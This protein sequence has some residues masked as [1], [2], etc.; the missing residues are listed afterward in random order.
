VPPDR[1]WNFA[2]IVEGIAGRYPDREAIRD[3]ARS[4][5]WRDF[6]R[7]TGALAAWLQERVSPRQ[8]TIAVY[9]RNCAEY[10]EAY[11]GVMKAGHV[12]MNV[13]F[14]Y[15][16]DEL[17]H[18]LD[19]ADVRL[20]VVHAEFLETASRVADRL[21]GITGWVVVGQ[22]AETGGPLPP[23]VTRYEDAVTGRAAG[24]DPGRCGS[25]V[26][27]MYT[28]GTTGL[29]K[30][31]VW[32]QHNLFEALVGSANRAMQ[33]PPVDSI[34]ELLDGLPAA[35]PRGLAAS[36]LMHSTGLLNQFM[37]LVSGGTAVVSQARSFDPRVVLETVERFGVTS[38]TIVGDAFARPLLA[39]LRDGARRYELSTLGLIVSSGAMWSREVKAGLLEQLPGVALYDAFGSS[40]GFGLGVS[41][42]LAGEV[43]DTAEFRL[44]AGVRVLG[45]DGE[46]IEPG[47][48]GIG[49]VAVTGALPEGYYK[50]PEKSAAT[51]PTIDGVRYSIAGDHVRV[52]R[53]GS[54]ALLGRG[55]ACINTGGEKVFPEEVEEVLKRCPG[56]DDAA[57]VGV[58]ERRLGSV[59]CAVVA[60]AAAGAPDAAAVMAHVRSS[61]AAYKTPR[62]VV[63]V[64]AV[65]RTVHGKVDYPAASRLA[66]RDR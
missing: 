26:V 7:R 15:G 51:W 1:G 47:Q 31:V 27:L 53:D 4:F 63:F 62:R 5:T 3:G 58:P 21:P 34:G 49:R 60:C 37:V 17:V 38:L 28:G 57:V 32:T 6:D 44:G 56:V 48:E 40:E 52:R 39:E 8:S 36:P 10:L 42:A 33:L 30:G 12:P 50:D 25:D 41:V 23:A 20:V 61:L 29:P 43:L 35:V 16:V 54:L 9:L 45:D 64:E 11:V 65:P 2:D 22:S 24:S 46:W 14:R 13:N 59:V 55:S 18:L 66:R 19:D